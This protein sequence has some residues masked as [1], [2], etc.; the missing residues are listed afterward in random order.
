[1]TEGRTEQITEVVDEV[2]EGRARATDRLMSVVY[3]ELRKL[4][5]DRLSHDRGN[6]SL[7]ATA[8]VHEAYVRL[9]VSSSVGSSFWVRVATAGSTMSKKTA[10]VLIVAIALLNCGGGGGDVR[11]PGSNREIRRWSA[12]SSCATSWV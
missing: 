7:Q 4:A 12:S 1:M 9:V 11:S 3:M 5:R 8:L 2:A 10:S 6:H